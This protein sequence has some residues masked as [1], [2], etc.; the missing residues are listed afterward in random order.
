MNEVLEQQQSPGRVSEKVR[1]YLETEFLVRDHVVGTRLPTVRDIAS[2]MKVSFPTVQAEIQRLVKDGYLRTEIGNGTFLVRSRKPQ[3]G[4]LHVAL[5][6]KLPEESSEGGRYKNYQKLW[7]QRVYGGILSRALECPRP[8]AL[9]QLA[10]GIDGKVSSETLIEAADKV[11]GAILLWSGYGREVD[12]AYQAQGKPLVHFNL[13]D[14]MATANFV[15]FDPKSAMKRCTEAAMQT[16]RKRFLLLLSSKLQDEPN[17]RLRYQA[18]MYV[19]R[20]EKNPHL[21]LQLSD[22]KSYKIQDGKVAMQSILETGYRPDFVICSGDL[23]ALGAIEALQ[24][25]GL[26][27][28]DDVSVIGGSG[29]DLERESWPEL[30]RTQQPLEILG[31]ELLSM[32]WRRIELK[33]VE[34]PG[35]FLETPFRGGASTRPEENVILG[36]AATGEEWIEE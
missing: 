36:L 28:P 17:Y 21:A 13:Q 31:R 4:T 27:V 30:T 16:G 15:A 25:K 26:R 34:L 1:R 24:K 8:V 11:D 18:M 9:T 14:E 29:F 23:L 20:M 5:S 3:Q 32:L 33:G 35:M 6:Q 22:A 10:A 12:E 7:T 2:L 19:L